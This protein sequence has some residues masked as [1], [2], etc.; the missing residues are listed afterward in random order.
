MSPSDTLKRS[1]VQEKGGQE[2]KDNL[3]GDGNDAGLE[4]YGKDMKVKAGVT[5]K[6]SSKVSKCDDLKVSQS[7]VHAKGGK[8]N[9]KQGVAKGGVIQ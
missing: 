2:S 8:Q 7:K 9:A 3:E 1:K 4:V 5:Q 6:E